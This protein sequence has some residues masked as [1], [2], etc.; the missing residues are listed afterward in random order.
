MGHYSKSIT[1]TLPEGTEEYAGDIWI[2]VNRML[3]K[4]Q[5]NIHK[6]HWDEVQVLDALKGLQDEMCE[7]ESAINNEEAENV[8]KEAADVANFAMILSSVLDRKLNIKPF[9][10]GTQLDLFESTPTLQWIDRV[11]NQLKDSEDQHLIALETIITD[12]QLL[13]FKRIA[14]S[15][16]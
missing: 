14:S 13:T 7:L 9:T 16:I 10:K 2:F 12:S 1:I 4:L 5:A 3:G 8:H 11:R 15:V 6:G